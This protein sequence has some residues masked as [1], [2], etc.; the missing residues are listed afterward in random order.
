[1]LSLEWVTDTVCHVPK[2]RSLK[3]FIKDLNSCKVKNVVT[4]PVSGY[5]TPLKNL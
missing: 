3:E 1:M 2:T 4:Y 5:Q